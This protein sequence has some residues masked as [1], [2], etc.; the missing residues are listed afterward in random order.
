MQPKKPIAG[1]ATSGRGTSP[2][3]TTA[4]HRAGPIPGVFQRG[5]GHKPSRQTQRRL[6]DD[7]QCHLHQLPSLRIAT[8]AGA[9]LAGCARPT[10]RKEAVEAISAA[11][12]WAGT[13]PLSRFS[14]DLP[15]PGHATPS[16][17]HS[18]RGV[19]DIERARLARQCAFFE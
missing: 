4:C 16:S 8:A 2:W 6:H 1:P 10:S 18:T 7:T 11:G 15:G 13:A 5:A 12:G 19:D 17:T 9:V 3:L 14:S